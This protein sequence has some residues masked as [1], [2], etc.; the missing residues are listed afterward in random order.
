[1]KATPLLS[2]FLLLSLI[3][4]TNVVVTE[5]TFEVPNHTQVTQKE[6]SAFIVKVSN[7]MWWEDYWLMKGRPDIAAQHGIG[8]GTDS[9][10]DLIPFQNMTFIYWSNGSITIGPPH[11]NPFGDA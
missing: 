8:N 10:R 3:Q 6:P 4:R 1:M 11:F 5:T 9:S 2:L 7:C